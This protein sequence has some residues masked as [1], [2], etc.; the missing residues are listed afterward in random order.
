MIEI[1][2]QAIIT[3]QRITNLFLQ[4]ET[5]LQTVTVFVVFSSALIPAYCFPLSAFQRRP[6]RRL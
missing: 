6:R 3:W 5:F 4:K 1:S 2:N